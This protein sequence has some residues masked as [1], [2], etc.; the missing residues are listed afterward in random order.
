MKKIFINIYKSLVFNL[1]KLMYGKIIYSKDNFDNI[2]IKRN[3]LQDERIFYNSTTK[4]SIIKIYN[5]RVCT[6]YVENVA[7]INKNKIVNDV[8]FQQVN[9]ELKTSDFNS[10]IYKGTP[11]LKK[12]FAGQVLS[13]TQGASGHKNY[14]HWLFDILPKIKICSK[15]YN[16]EKI[17][18][19][20]LSNLEDYQ[21]ITLDYLGLKNIKI[22]D[23]HKNRHIQADELLVCEHPWYKKGF[24]HEE[25]KNLPNWI[26]EWIKTTF[27]QFG[28]KFDCN[29]KIF[30]DRSE[31]PFSHC[32]IKNNTEIIEFLENKGF[33]SYKIGQLTFQN[34]IYLFNNA[35]V[36]VGAHGAAFANLAFCKPNAKIIEIKPSWHPSL[37]NKRISEINNLDYNLI[38]TAKIQNGKTGQGDILLDKK[39]ID[40][41]L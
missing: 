31:S 36:I 16:L 34:Q 35:K 38:E 11:Y 33:K 25:N 27:T 23:C 17:K 13:L 2:D 28:K 39:L 14:F 7:I 19:L 37:V 20:Y 24:I 22:I 29:D 9:G 18:Y 6:D 40:N 12:K 30:I 21:K 5:G 10:F 15:V 1:F 8:S 41:F 4:Y 3:Y 26:V 32:Q